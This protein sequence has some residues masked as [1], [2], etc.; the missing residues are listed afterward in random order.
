MKQ[1]TY[2][3]LNVWRTRKKSEPQM[4]L[5]F[6]PSSPIIVIIIIIITITN[7]TFFYDFPWDKF[8]SCIKTVSKKSTASATIKLT[9][10][11]F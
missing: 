5:G 10:L 3:K 9:S 6:F 11:A 8:N 1:Q 2:D 4:G 7:C